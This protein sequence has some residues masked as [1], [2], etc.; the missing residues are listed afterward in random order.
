MQTKRNLKLYA[1]T[2][3]QT[4]NQNEKYRTT[5]PLC[6]DTLPPCLDK[7]LLFKEKKG[8]EGKGKIKE[9]NLTRLGA[10]CT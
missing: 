5:L 3:M 4:N 8:G 1:L 7:A 2:S 9:N 10:K 6:L